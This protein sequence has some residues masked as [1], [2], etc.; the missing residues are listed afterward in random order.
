M[1]FKAFTCMFILLKYFF[2]STSYRLNVTCSPRGLGGPYAKFKNILSNLKGVWGCMGGG[3]GQIMDYF[4][5]RFN[6]L[7]HGVLFR[8]HRQTE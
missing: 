7:K 8:G 4:S 1:Y 6:S 3:G 2:P 5:L